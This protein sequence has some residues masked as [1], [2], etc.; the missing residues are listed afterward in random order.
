MQRNYGR[1]ILFCLLFTV[2][3]MLYSPKALHIYS[4]D[5]PKNIL[6]LNSYHKGLS[7]TDGETEG[8]YNTLKNY[9][10]NFNLSVE[11]MDWKNYP[12]EENLKDI[13]RHLKYKY[14]N[15]KI[16]IVITTDDAALEFALKNREDIFKD[17]PIVF[18]GVNEKGIAKLTKGHK[19]VVGV[20]EIVD[21]IGTVKAA[22]KLKPNLKEIYVLFD[23]TESGISTGEITIKAIRDVS[24]SIKINTLNDKC[25]EDIFQEVGRAPDDSAVLITTYYRD[26]Y[27]MIVGFEEFSLEVSR[28]SRVPVFHLYDFGLD[29]GAIGGSVLSGKLE[30]EQAGKLAVRILEG[31]DIS[32]IP[33]VTSR[34]T[35]YMFDY[36]QL[37]KFNIP[38]ERVPESSTVINKPF[39]FFETYRSIVITAI[40]IFLL[41]IVFIIILFIYLGKIHRMRDELH[42]KHEKLIDS[43]NRLKQQFE[44]LIM[45]QQDLSSSEKR[46]SLL[47]E[48]M[49]NAFAVL[50]PVINNEGK[51]V[52]M[53][54]INV[55]PGF[56][57][58]IGLET[59]DIVGKAWMEV[60]KYPNKNLK[61]YHEILHTGET[62]HFDTYYPNINIYYSA[63]AFKLSDSQIGVVFNNITEYKEAIKEITIL[64]DE[65]EQRVA[66]RTDELQSAVNELESFAYTVSHDL[67]SPL[68]AVDGY[69]RILKE[70]FECKLGA[71][72]I[73][74][75][76][77]IRHI[78]KDMID[79]ISKLLKYSTASETE[80]VKEKV[81]I[82]EILKSI[83][84]ELISVNINR[85]ITLIIETGLPTVFADKILIRQVIYN[86]LSNAVKF[87]KNRET[88]L[89]NVGCTITGEE[90]IFYVKD[91]GAGFD[92]DSSSKLFSIFQRLHASDEFEGSGIGLVTVK[93]IIQRHGGRVWIEGKTEIGATVYFTLPFEG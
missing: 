31:E 82:E 1:Y 51:L 56:E 79:M 48:K 90:Y 43:D 5:T 63:N 3:I 9:D 2:A 60:F 29:N 93:K 4:E 19:A 80:I 86:I 7:W 67:K 54:F 24:P 8:I 83:F 72:G 28:R 76:S 70:D 45:A 52:D 46:Y 85:D 39:S 30:G 69:S 33:I 38:L 88:A 18:C 21:P 35:T 42:E 58:Q 15:K 62:K 22:L 53:R 26:L 34:T 23:N 13:Y 77:N 65:L 32:K 66:E 20:A 16:D 44:K 17:V 10:K 11:Y 61:I 40:I 87:T 49:M 71:E 41:L 14:S 81:D 91:N 68:R 36:N 78:C 92:M 50:E 57:E 37:E 64:N 89:I 25:I 47:F 74:I 75:I 12:E 55:N 84:K 73:E 59:V 6:I 27:D